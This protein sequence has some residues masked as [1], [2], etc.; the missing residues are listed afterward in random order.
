MTHEGRPTLEDVFLLRI[1]RHF[2]VRETRVIVGR[3]EGENKILLSAAERLQLPYMSVIGYKGPITLLMDSKE[4]AI[5]RG[6]ALTVRY[7]D[8]PK[9]S[10]VEVIYASNDM[11]TISIEAISEEELDK[12]RI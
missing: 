3:N 11:Y 1:G 4:E 10:S 9:Q 7:S 8:A 12:L 6:A 2:R 5:R